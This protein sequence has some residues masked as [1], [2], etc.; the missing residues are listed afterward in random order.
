MKH[1]NILIIAAAMLMTAPAFSATPDSDD[2]GA[3]QT[4][5]VNEET[6][7]R[8]VSEIRVDG[9][10]VVLL[11]TDGTTQ[12]AD[13]RL[14]TL[15]MSYEE[16]TDVKEVNG[17]KEVNENSWYT[18][19]GIKVTVMPKQKGVYIQNGKKVVNK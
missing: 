11:F 5:T 1:K 17:V 3:T 19:D 10:N 13:M 8:T 12:T 2:K 9:N 15:T 6:V 14:V 7:E 4:L 18:L 16:V